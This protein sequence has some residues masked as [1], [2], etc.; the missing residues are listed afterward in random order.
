ML[1]LVNEIQRSC[2]VFGQQV[3]PLFRACQSDQVAPLLVRAMNSD[4]VQA[5]LC[6]G[7]HFH[8][9][10]HYDSC[11][12]MVTGSLSGM[13]TQNES[14]LCS[15]N[16]SLSWSIFAFSGRGNGDDGFWTGHGWNRGCLRV[17]PSVASPRGRNGTSISCVYADPVLVSPCDDAVVIGSV[18]CSKAID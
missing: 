15:M 4:S 1:T 2:C 3:Y 5:A 7:G 18:T 6:V 13:M 11:S 12:W 16:G 10:N 17:F 14:A 9:Q 8:R